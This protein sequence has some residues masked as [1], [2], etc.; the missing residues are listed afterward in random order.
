MYIGFY[1][2]LIL[3]VLILL[4]YYK[5]DNGVYEAPFMLAY[6]S[7]FVMLPQ[8]ASIYSIDLYNTPTF[9]LFIYTIIGSNI[10]FVL[11]FELSNRNKKKQSFTIIEYPKIRGILYIFTFL[12]F[13]SIFILMVYIFFF[14]FFI[15]SCIWVIKCPNHGLF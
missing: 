3:N 8:L 2:Y 10:A 11:G 12:G 5:K 4:Y 1:L 7:V 14:F 9:P 6:I 15:V 13:Y